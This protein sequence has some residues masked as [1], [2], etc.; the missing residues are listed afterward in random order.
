MRIFSGFIPRP[1]SPK[2]PRLGNVGCNIGT[3]VIL[4]GPAERGGGWTSWSVGFVWAPISSCSPK[5]IPLCDMLLLLP[6]AA[7]MCSA[8]L[9]VASTWSSVIPKPLR[10][11]E[12]RGRQDYKTNHSAA[13]HVRVRNTHV[14]A[15][16]AAKRSVIIITGTRSRWCQAHVLGQFAAALT[17][18][19]QHPRGRGYNTGKAERS[20]MQRRHSWPA[21]FINSSLAVQHASLL[22]RAKLH[23]FPSFLPSRHPS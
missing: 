17:P 20:Y 7:R 21:G 5:P 19:L 18:R 2:Q 16:N 13:A 11:T 14:R 10:N 3:W 23:V 8:A 4:L 1:P 9:F 15:R 12:A 22:P 6:V